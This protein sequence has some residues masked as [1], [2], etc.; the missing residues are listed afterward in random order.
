M[1]DE[2]GS[3]SPVLKGGIVM[4]L[5]RGVDGCKAG[6]LVVTADRETGEIVAAVFSH[7]DGFLQDPKIEVTAI[8]IP[9]GLPDSGP[10]ACDL[11]AR[12]LI[13]RRGVSVFP[14][15]ARSAI[16]ASTYDDARRASRTAS[17]KSLSKQTY[18]IMPKIR[19]VD[20]ILRRDRAVAEPV[21]EVHPEVCFYF[22]NDRNRLRHPKRMPFGI[23]E[24]YSL[25]RKPFE[26]V[27]EIVRD[28]VPKSAA[29]EDDVLDALA[30]LWTA[31]RIRE[32]S[33]SRI[34][35]GQLEM[36]AHGLPMQM[37]A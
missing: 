6:W 20:E 7:A 34:P 26:G 23:A 29:A 5:V 24:R 33:S 25:L 9:I 17:G 11:E 16:A 18:A 21:Y 8:D 10:R 30:A 13:G 27:A 12:R 31:R 28:S 19:E 15:P 22:L 37:L 32:G 36:D 14:T 2:S 4:S 1:Q 3:V 35:S